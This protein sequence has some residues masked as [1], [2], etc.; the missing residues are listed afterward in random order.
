MI[1]SET[2]WQYKQSIPSARVFPTKKMKRATGAV[3]NSRAVKDSSHS[4]I[5]ILCKYRALAAITLLLIFQF[6]LYDFNVDEY[7]SS[8]PHGISTKLIKTT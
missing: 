6:A 2:N 7:T 1:L 8:N 5:S 4:L 3:Y